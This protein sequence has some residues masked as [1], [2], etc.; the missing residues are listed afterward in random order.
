MITIPLRI[1]L[2][3]DHKTDAELISYHLGQLVETLEIRVVDNLPQLNLELQ[4]FV[5]DLVIS[6]YNMPTCTGLDMLKATK[7]FDANLPFIF[8][9]GT[10]E[11]EEM[12]ANTILA[13]ASGFIL[14]KNMHKLQEKLNPLLKRV[15]FNISQ[16]NVVR[17]RVRKNK[18]VVNQIYQYLDSIKA[19]NEEQRENLKI[20]K[21]NIDEIELDKDD[22]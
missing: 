22:K 9:T 19:E 6:D 10:I 2:A 1:L 4:N 5:P 17:E 11:D 14:K 21:E 16:Q 20:I 3:E 7:E 12:A 8:I 15:V 13:G 18:I